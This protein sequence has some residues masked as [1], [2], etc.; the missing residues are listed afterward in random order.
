[1]DAE[2]AAVAE[3]DL[4][5]V[6]FTE[7]GIVGFRG[8]VGYE[9]VVLAAEFVAVLGRKHLAAFGCRKHV[10]RVLEEG[11]EVSGDV[12]GELKLFVAA[13]CHGV[14]REVALGVVR[15]GPNGQSHVVAALFRSARVEPKAVVAVCHVFVKCASG[16]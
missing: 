6:H 14:N 10:V 8:G 15:A 16:G 1:M 3:A 13:Q 9:G 7:Q 2:V 5:A 12:V 4:G 11:R